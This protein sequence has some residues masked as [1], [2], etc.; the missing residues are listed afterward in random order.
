M[1][2]PA[3]GVADMARVVCSRGTV[4]AYAWDMRG[5]GFPYEALHAEMRGMGLAVP[6]PP[7]AEASRLDVMRELWTGAGLE[8]VDTREIPV[9]D[10]RRLR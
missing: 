7:S 3:K 8:A 2:D 1:P 5:G 4:A 10:V 6:S 9:T